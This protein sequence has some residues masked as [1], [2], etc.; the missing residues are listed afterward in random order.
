MAK[1]WVANNAD[2][3]RALQAARPPGVI[4]TRDPS[5]RFVRLLQGIAD[6]LVRVHGRANQLLEE[7]DPQTTT[8]M[9]ADWERVCALPE[10]DY[11]PPDMAARRRVLVAKLRAAGAGGQS[12]QYFEELAAAHGFAWDVYAGPWTFY[13]TVKGAQMSRATCSSPCDT[14]LATWAPTAY[15]AACSFTQNKPAHA[16]IYWTGA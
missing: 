9:L 13:F 15:V 10:F 1:I 16:A 2:Y 12:A 6:E 11:V 5:R 8:E 3:V 14:P 4:W 7:A